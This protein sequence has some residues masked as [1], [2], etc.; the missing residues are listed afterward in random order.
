[1]CDRRLVRGAGARFAIQ[2]ILE[3]GMQRCVGMCV[4]LQG[5]QTSGIK[6]IPPEGFGQS[7]H[8]KACA[9]SLFRMAAVTHDHLDERLNVRADAHGLLSDTFRGPIFTE[10]MMCSHVISVGGVLT[11]ARGSGMGGNVLPFKIY[12]NRARGDPSP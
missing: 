11:V 3:N 8:T 2:T 1:M 9:V 12:L 5:P 7:Q 10:A 4:D 6:A